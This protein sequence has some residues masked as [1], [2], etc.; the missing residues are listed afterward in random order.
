MEEEQL[1]STIV[2]WRIYLKLVFYSVISNYRTLSKLGLIKKT[3]TGAGEGLLPGGEELPNVLGVGSVLF[4]YDF[5][6]GLYVGL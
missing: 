1:W 5:E 2:P 4:G 6:F 3:G